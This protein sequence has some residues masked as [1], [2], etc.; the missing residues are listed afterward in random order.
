[1]YTWMYIVRNLGFLKYSSSGIRVQLSWFVT[2][3]DFTYRFFSNNT[4]HPK[5]NVVVQFIS[6]LPH[7]AS[8]SYFSN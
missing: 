4:A 5:N 8:I 2:S 7:F 3:H 6:S 1:M